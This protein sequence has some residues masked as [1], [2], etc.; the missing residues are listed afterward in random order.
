M[1]DTSII[2]GAQ[3]EINYGYNGLGNRVSQTVNGVTT[4]YV[5]DQAAGL[6]QVLQVSAPQGYGTYTYLY[7]LGRLGQQGAGGMAYYLGDALGSVRQMA[8]GYDQKGRRDRR[9]HL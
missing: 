7:G 2:R 6:V 3:I 5:L 1:A 8:A 9:L 4:D